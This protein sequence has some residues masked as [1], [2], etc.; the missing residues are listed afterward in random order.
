MI[1]EDKRFYAKE[2]ADYLT[3]YHDHFRIIEIKRINGILKLRPDNEEDFR[4]GANPDV[5][6]LSENTIKISNIAKYLYL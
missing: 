1:S 2:E 3:F 6:C 5:I 4:E